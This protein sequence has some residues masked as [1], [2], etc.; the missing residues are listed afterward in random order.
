MTE[1]T[2]TEAGETLIGTDGPDLIFGLGGDDIIDGRGGADDMVGGFGDDIYYVDH[3]FDLV[4]EEA[5]QGYDRIYTTV[6]YVLQPGQHVEF[7]ST[8]HH[9]GTDP[10]N[11]TGNE[12][13]QILIG[14]AGNNVLNGGGG[15]DDMRGLGGD[16]IYYVDHAGDIVREA[17][18]GGYDIVYT[19]VSYT[20]MAGQEIEALSTRFHFGTEAINLTGNEYGQILIGNDGNNVLDGGGGADDM[21]GLGGNDIYYVDHEGD[22]VHEAAGGGNDTVYTT[23]SHAL[24]AGQ[25]VEVLSTRYHH[26]TEAID[27]AGNEY[28]N[29]LIGNAGSNILNGGLGNDLLQG[30]G[31]ADI[32]AFTTTLGPNNV[33]TIADFQAGLDKIMLGGGF[34]QPFAALAEGTLAAGAFTIGAAATSAAHR[35]IYNSATGALP[36]GVV[37]QGAGGA[38]V[39][40]PVGRAGRGRADREGGGGERAFGERGEGLAGRAAQ[41]DPVE[42]HL[43]VG[44]RV[45]IVGAECRGEGENVV[46]AQ[47]LEQIVAEP[48]VQ[49]VAAGIADQPVGEIVAGEVDRLGAVME[50]GGEDL[51][52]LAGHQRIA[53]HRVDDVVAATDALPHDVAGMIDIIGVVPAQPAHVVRAAAAVQHIV[54]GI[55]DQDLAIFVAGEVDRLGAVMEAGGKDLHFLAGCQRIADDTVDGVVAAAGGL[56]HDVAGMIDIISVVPAQP[57]HVVRAAAAVQ[58]IVAGIADQDL[59]E[60]VAGEVD[61]L[62]AVLEADG[63]GLD[64]L[65]GHQRIAD[66][67]IDDVVAAAGGLAHD[68]AGMIDIIDVVAAQAAHVVRAAAAV[69]HIVAGIAEQDLAELVAG[70]VDRIGAVVGTGGKDL[71]MLARRQRVADRGIDGVLAAIDPF[72]DQ[73]VRMIDIIGVVAGAAMHLVGAAAPV[74]DVVA[75]EPEDDVWP[76]SADQRLTRF[77]ARDLN[78]DP[79]P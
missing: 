33:D 31:G 7:L 79:T 11:L 26:G 34:G 17:A 57:A 76:R 66:H 58:Y 61:R 27:L 40:D 60:L 20:L 65:A 50:A 70:Q 3:P 64:M 43:E 14:N 75:A 38:V 15:A 5:N 29:R 41:H 48:A 19:E 30:L 4:F 69:Q 9:H 44:D 37:E 35:I 1:I 2:G 24:A 78:H 53:D 23:V 74:D 52:L 25:E 47:A 21:R 45:H 39:D 71:D 18:G 28:A 42:T 10:I 16:D 73:V 36:V 63:E 56:A 22:V 8:R 32:F 59:A 77:R 6:S 54:A 72:E 67:R 62:G 13:S 55:A 68:V 12:L 51:H 49:Y 46:P